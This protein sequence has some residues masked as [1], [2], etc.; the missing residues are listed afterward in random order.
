MISAAAKDFVLV[1]P[2]TSIGELYRLFKSSKEHI[3]ITKVGD[4]YALVD[5]FRRRA[6]VADYAEGLAVNVPNLPANTNVIDAIVQLGE[7]GIGILVR[8]GKPI[9][10]ITSQRLQALITLHTMSKTGK[11]RN[12]S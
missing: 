6:A 2:G 7:T 1:D 3:I 4:G 9:G 5:L 10:I 8:G 11:K 12:L